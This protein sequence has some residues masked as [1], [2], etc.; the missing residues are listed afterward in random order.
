MRRRARPA[1]NSILAVDVD[2]VL[3]DPDR[4]GLGPWGNALQERLGIDRGALREAFFAPYW[5]DIVV[6]RTPIE[7][8]LAEALKSL[9]ASASV[10]DVLAC[11]FDADFVV[12]EPVVA[13]VRDLASTGVTIVLATNQECRRLAFLRERLRRLLPVAAVLGS[14]ELGAVKADERFWR[15][16]TARLGL[17]PGAPPPVLLDDDATNVEVALRCGWGAV[18]FTG[19]GGWM[20]DVRRALAPRGRL[21]A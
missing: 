21:P 16:A 18:H 11:W 8:V 19:E 7:P 20:D 2:G 17:A 9:G 13:A 15:A 12:N 3:L 14:A 6:G 10:D 5:D 4:G 1:L